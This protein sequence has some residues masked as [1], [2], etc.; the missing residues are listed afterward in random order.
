[1][2][3]PHEK[4]GDGILEDMLDYHINLK[5]LKGIEIRSEFVYG[6]ISQHA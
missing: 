2:I 6:V 3:K 5:F 1:M 4:Y